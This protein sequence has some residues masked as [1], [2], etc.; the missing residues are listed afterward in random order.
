MDWNKNNPRYRRPGKRRKKGKKLGF[1]ARLGAKLDALF[2]PKPPKAAMKKTLPERPATV[3]EIFDDLKISTPRARSMKNEAAPESA[4][5]Q[6]ALLDIPAPQTEEAEAAYASEDFEL[7]EKLEAD[8]LG[9]TEEQDTEIYEEV[10]FLD[11]DDEEDEEDVAPPEDETEPEEAPQKAPKNKSF[12]RRPAAP[13]PRWLKPVALA[14]AAIL[15]V[16]GGCWA[17]REAGLFSGPPPTPQVAKIPVTSLP[18]VDTPPPGLFENYAARENAAHVSEYTIEEGATLSQ[19][20]EAV[21]LG[22][23][24]AGGA[25]VIDCLT[26]EADLDVVRPGAVLRA[27]WQDAEKT[28]LRRLEYHPASGDPPIVVRAGLDGGFWCYTLSAPALTVTTAARGTVESTLWE[29]GSGA[30]LDAAI[31]VN[32]A[33]M[34]ASEIDFLSDIQEGD[35]FQVLYNRNYADGRPVGGV[36]IEMLHMSNKGTD[37]ELYRYVNAAGDVGYYDQLGRSSKKTFFNSPLQYTR[38]SSGFSLNRLHP[39]FKVRRAH[40]G[41]DYAAPS[42]TPISSVADGV[43]TFAGWSGG[44]GRLISI[45][46]DEVYS[47]M[48]AHMSRF[49]KGLKKGDRVAQG[50]LIGYVGAT[51]TATG[52]HLDFRMKRNNVFIDPQTVL[53]KQEGR[54]LEAAEAQAFAQLVT[55]ARNRMREYLEASA[56]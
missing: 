42:G 48:Y 55:G 6:A 47:T 30:G 18:K 5:P 35:S 16:A 44:Y 3:E 54:M 19:A 29:A 34:M 20:L 1:F 36:T 41:V 25:A 10:V 17:A 7:D 22:T 33:D 8:Y 11:E 43:I 49:A 14:A 38:I 4:A 28:D 32:M 21:G 51:G 46:H 39:I 27:Y 13:K 56:L 45:K 53:T 50:D 40:E 52:P 9:N 24:T 2:R 15:I 12:E 26:A 37:Y 23:R 31:I